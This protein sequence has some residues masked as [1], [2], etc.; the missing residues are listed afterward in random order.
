MSVAL[1]SVAAAAQ[2]LAQAPP[3]SGGS[4]G[5][6][7]GTAE[8]VVFWVL[9]P[10]ALGSAIGMVFA[11][12]AVHAALLLVLDF[13]CL[14]VFYAVQGAPFL[15]AV[16][17]I[18][19]TGAIMILFLFVLMLIGVDSADSLKETIRGQRAAAFVAGLGFAVIVIAGLGNALSRTE[20][21]GLGE[22]NAAGNVLGIARLLFTRYVFAFE[23]TSALL[24]IAALGAMVLAHRERVGPRVTQRELMVRRFSGTH[25]TPMPGPGAL[26]S[27]QA[28]DTPAPLPDGSPAPGSVDP[29]F[30]TATSGSTGYGSA[31]GEGP[32]GTRTVDGPGRSAQ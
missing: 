28:V 7:P 22:A 10:I 13:F 9:G 11:R 17:V 14:A 8:A 18:V 6:T 24:I 25:P 32:A 5:G 12:N 21:T 4:T 3:A 29:A 2:V 20:P 16:Q 23:I 31:G 30:S 19:Y 1:H 15:A 26:A 27:G